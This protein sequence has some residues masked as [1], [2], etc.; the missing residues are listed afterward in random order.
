MRTFTKE[1]QSEQRQVTALRR[2]LEPDANATDMHGFKGELGT[3]RPQHFVVRR[4]GNVRQQIRMRTSSGSLESYSVRRLNVR[5]GEEP[6]FARAGLRGLAVNGESR[7]MQ[8]NGSC[9]RA[10]NSAVSDRGFDLGK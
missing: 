4:V 3:R 8:A 5:F 1:L 6:T 10:G 9:D 7:T 2:H